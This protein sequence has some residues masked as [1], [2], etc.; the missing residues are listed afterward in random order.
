MTPLSRGPQGPW[1]PWECPLSAQDMGGP[2]LGLR[3][4]GSRLMATS[5][6]P[7]PDF[8]VCLWGTHRLRPPPGLPV[9]LGGP[10]DGGH[11][12]QRCDASLLN[13][14]LSFKWTDV[15]QP[16]SVRTGQGCA[17]RWARRRGTG[18]VDSWRSLRS[19]Y[20]LLKEGGLPAGK[21]SDAGFGVLFEIL[22]SSRKGGT[23]QRYPPLPVCPLPW[24]SSALLPTW[25]GGSWAPRPRL[26]GL[27]GLGTPLPHP[28]RCVWGPMLPADTDGGGWSKDVPLLQTSSFMS[29]SLTI[30]DTAWG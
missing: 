22:K 10:W 2:W 13:L 7:C 17:V 1:R 6:G 16:S 29:M 4:P 8:T 28:T 19:G 26:L 9:S 5:G 11:G 27:P 15:M 14:D 23:N 25:G 18:G 12:A 20:H 3:S 30:W 24:W 21:V